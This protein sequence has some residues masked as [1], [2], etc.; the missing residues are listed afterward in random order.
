MV[1]RFVHNFEVRHPCCVE[2]KLLNGKNTVK[3]QP[4]LLAISGWIT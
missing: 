4:Y 2:P 3:T 1:T